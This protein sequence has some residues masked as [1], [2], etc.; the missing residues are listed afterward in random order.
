MH[1]RIAKYYLNGVQHL[2][3]KAIGKFVFGQNGLS[4]VEEDIQ[5]NVSKITVGAESI[6]T[7]KS[8]QSMCT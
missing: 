5:S 3:T 6:W 1:S 2:F 7:C 8:N 4:L